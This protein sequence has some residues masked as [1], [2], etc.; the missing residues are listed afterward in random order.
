MRRA[1][2]IVPALLALGCPAKNDSPVC[3]L[4]S[5]AAALV[6]RVKGKDRNISVGAKLRPSDHL[7]ASGDA[8]I[9]CF[10]GALRQIKK[11]DDFEVGDLI[12]AKIESTN[13][14]RMRLVEGKLVPVEAMRRTVIARYTDNQFTPQSAQAAN[15]PTTDDYLVAFFTPNGF[16][17]LT[18]PSPE[19]PRNLA[20]PPL[21]AK[22][23]FVHAGDL[24]QGPYL[25]TVDAEV[26]FAETD[27]LATAALL[28]DKTY[29][30]GRTVRLIL[31][32]GAEATL[33]LG[34]H[35]VVKLE[36]PI[37]LDLR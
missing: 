30:L 32:R 5:A 3:G 7:H 20:P 1:F 36:G 9:E 27:D 19:G 2:G 31:P 4:H 25:L 14:P 29:P 13:V 34:L 16:A 28:E 12:E 6:T 22:V 23:P 24:G 35:R 18:P 37:D 8:M 10:G 17:K 11:G 26:A 33:D 21:R 15:E